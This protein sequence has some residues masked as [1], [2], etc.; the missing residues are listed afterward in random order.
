M[1]AAAL[2]QVSVCATVARSPIARSWVSSEKAEQPYESTK[3]LKSLTCASRTVEATPRLVTMPQMNSVSIPA[4]RRTHSSR[5]HIEGR[6]G[7]FFDR[8]VGGLQFIR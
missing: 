7:D 6:I 8:E 3:V 5:V 4:L 2:A 1:S